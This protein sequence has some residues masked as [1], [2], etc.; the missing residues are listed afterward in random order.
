[1]LEYAKTILV[2]V[3]F[4]KILFEKELRKAL[5]M[6]VPDELRELRAW[7]YQQFARVYRTILNRV[8]GQAATA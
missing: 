2:K 7:C 8:F 1:M 4:D 5:R 3:S 6:L